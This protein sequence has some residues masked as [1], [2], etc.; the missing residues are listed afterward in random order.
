MGGGE[1]RERK[2]GGQGRN[3]KK[4]GRESKERDK[5]RGD[6]NANVLLLPVLQQRAVRGKTSKQHAHRSFLI[7]DLPAHTG[8]GSTPSSLLCL[9]S[10]LSPPPDLSFL[11]P[12]PLRCLCSAPALSYTTRPAQSGL[13]SSYAQQRPRTHLSLLLGLARDA[14][15][16]ALVSG[17][18]RSA[19]AQ[20]LPADAGRTCHG[21]YYPALFFS[22]LFWAC[23]NITG[24]KEAG[25]RP[26]LCCKRQ[27]RFCTCSCTC[28]MARPCISYQEGR[29]NAPCRKRR[30]PL[31]SR[32]YRTKR[33]YLPRN[34][35]A[36]M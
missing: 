33:T 9:L 11:A 4:G 3:E 20:Q 28:N 21:P 6:K 10:S 15:P 29:R 25:G 27:L 18:V 16:R 35:S 2:R 22:L 19:H 31:A 12:P 30:W 1:R 24:R 7:S 36:L 13:S 26:A 32:R 14:W 34:A 17:T 8:P 23:D 5:E